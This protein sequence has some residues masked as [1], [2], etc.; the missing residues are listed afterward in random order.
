M[1]TNGG[2]LPRPPY[3]S[4]L[5]ALEDTQHRA[6]PTS[7]E[8]LEQ[9]RLDESP[10]DP[11]FTDDP[12]IRIEERA[13]PGP[14]GDIP[15]KLFQSSTVRRRPRGLRPGILFLHAGGRIQGNP[16]VGLTAVSDTIKELDAIIVSPAYRRAPEFQHDAAAEDCYAAL[17]W[18]EKHFQQLNIDPERLLI[19][20]VSAGGGLAASTALMVRDKGGP[21]L[22]GQL[23]AC[24][25]L[26]DRCDSL[27]NKQF[28]L[29]TRGYYTQFGHYAWKCVLGDLA[30][31][32]GVSYYAAAGR[33][34]DLSNLPPAYIDVGSAE[35][36]RDEDI[37][38]ATKLWEGGV[39]ADL[40]VWSGGS[41]GFDL[42]ES[43]TWLG[44]QAKKARLGWLARTLG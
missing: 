24:P 36:F 11:V 32:D 43:P 5:L 3:D 33:A 39:Q 20:G 28:D 13:V 30:G 29:E 21:R 2:S 18:I 35:S 7:K 26:D 15:V 9:L 10:T 40:H 17:L 41:H 14:R 6:I 4:D 37:A 12:T 23:L 1:A 38:F 25:M 19:A 27:S 8:E 44:G 34:T 31:Q 22:C 16:F 42:F